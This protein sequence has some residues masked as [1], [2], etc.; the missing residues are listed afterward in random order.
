MKQI[1][2]SIP[3]IL[4]VWVL[5]SVQAL[6]QTGF[7]CPK[8]GTIV[9]RDTVKIRYSGADP[10]DPFVCRA[11]LPNRRQ[12]LLF[13]NVYLM[14]NLE[15]GGNKPAEIALQKLFSGDQ[16]SVMFDLALQL[17]PSEYQNVSAHNTWTR[18][19]TETMKIGERSIE[20]TVYSVELSWVEGSTAGH[21]KSQLW[22]DPQTGVF[23]KRK[24]ISAWGPSM[25]LGSEWQVRSITTP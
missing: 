4:S 19:G 2:H 20:A 10:S 16:S 15:P 12:L 17:S 14:R 21:S 8:A 6:A 13:F 25:T 3:V 1:A 18:V 22:F 5:I 24:P 23:I 11:T 7:R 9:E